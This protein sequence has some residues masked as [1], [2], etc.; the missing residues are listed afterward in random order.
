MEYV[1]RKTGMVLVIEQDN[2]PENPR[3]WDTLGK[4]VCFHKRY[5][6]GDEH[7]LNSVDFGTWDDMETHLYEKM[8]ACLVLPLYLYDHSGITISTAPFSCPWDSG[9]I[10]FIYATKD[11]MKKDFGKI[12]ISDAMKAMEKILNSEVE[13]YDL[14]L[15]G[16][17]YRYTMFKVQTCDLGYEH[18]ISMD[19]CWGFYGSDPEENG[20]FDQAE[21]DIS[22]W[23]EVG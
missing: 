8:G 18:R 16:E 11:E 1:N 13:L 9:Q 20:I 6:L 19:S 21:V 4:M 22:E 3:E 14:Y 23:E 5:N 10:G 2:D 12:P 7:D 17:V 15:C